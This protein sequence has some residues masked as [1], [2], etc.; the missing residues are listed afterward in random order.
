MNT[1]ATISSITPAVILWK[2]MPAIKAEN[3]HPKANMKKTMAQGKNGRMQL[4]IKCLEFSLKHF[5]EGGC[6]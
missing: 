4:E 3:A 2:I 6:L 5:K 1:K